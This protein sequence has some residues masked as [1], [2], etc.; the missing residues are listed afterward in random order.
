M[1]T[2]PPAAEVATPATAHTRVS[3]ADPPRDRATAA[4]PGRDRTPRPAARVRHRGRRGPRQLL[5]GLLLA[6]VLMVLAG[7]ASAYELWCAD[8]PVVAVEGRL[9]DIQVQ[10]PV[11]HLLEMRSTTLT[12]VIPRNTTGAVVVD[13]VS[14]F[15][16]RTSIAPTGPPWAGTGGVPVTLVVEVEAATS[17]PIRL[18]ATSLTTSVMVEGTANVPLRL[19][20]VLP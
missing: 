1:P 12:V 18:V 5:A 2:C 11:D 6:A 8:D 17:Y 13:D 7:G 10:M 9:L 15:P 19:P 20:L 4:L 14:A 16:M 3:T